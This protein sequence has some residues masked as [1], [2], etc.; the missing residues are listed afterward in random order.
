MKKLVYCALLGLLTN[1]AHAATCN[2][3][4]GYILDVSKTSCMLRT[5]IEREATCLQG[6][7]LIDNKSGFEDSCTGALKTTIPAGIPANEVRA[8]L[9]SWL[10]AK[11]RGVDLW[12]KQEF[13]VV[14]CSKGLEGA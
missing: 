9:P 3:P 10:L 11:H 1:H 7:L 13:K 14:G 8:E 5:V 6:Q 12:R 2:C 4:S